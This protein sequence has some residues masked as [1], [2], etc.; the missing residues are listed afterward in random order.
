MM[1]EGINFNSRTELHMFTE[2]SEINKDEILD[3]HVNFAL[4]S[5]LA[6]LH[7][8]RALKCYSS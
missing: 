1:W 2:T 3:P 8:T 6:L 4:G 7:L 5:R